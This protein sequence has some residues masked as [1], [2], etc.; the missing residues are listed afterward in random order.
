MGTQQAIHLT[1][2]RPHRDRDHFH[3]PAV[4]LTGDQ[5]RALLEGVPGATISDDGD[6]I[7]VP[8]APTFAAPTLATT[9]LADER[10]DTLLDADDTTWLQHALATYA[11]RINRSE[12]LTPHDQARANDLRAALPTSRARDNLRDDQVAAIL[13]ATD[14]ADG[15]V[16]EADD[17]GAGK[18]AISLLTVWSRDATPGIIVCKPGLRGMWERE[19][20]KWLG[21]TYT[22]LTLDG[23]KPL[24]GGIPTDVDFV[25]VG[26]QV[27]HH[28]IDELVEF[29]AR[30][31]LVDESQQIKTLPVT[32]RAANAWLN[33]P[34]GKK[35]R[36]PR[37]GSWRTWAVQTLAKQPHVTTV[38]L[39]SATPNPNG[40]HLELLPQLDAL[41]YLDEFGGP[42]GFKRR[43]CRYCKPCDEWNLDVCS[44][45]TYPKRFGRENTDGSIN[46]REL[47]QRLRSLTMMRRSARQLQRDVDAIR[48]VDTPVDLTKDGRREYDRAEHDFI[49]YVKEHAAA[50]AADRGLTVAQAVARA[51]RSAQ[52]DHETLVQATHLRRLAAQG[53]I[54]DTVKY[55]EELVGSTAIDGTSEKAVVFAYHREVQDALLARWPNAPR[56]LAASEQPKDSIAADTDRF[57][58]DPDERLIVC[59]LDAAS[60]G[61]TLTAAWH[62]V[63]TQP[64]FV[65]AKVRQAVGRVYARSND[66]HSATLHRLYAPRT[67]EE[68]V[69]DTLDAKRTVASVTL[70]GQSREWGEVEKSDATITE[71]IAERLLLRQQRA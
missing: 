21:D 23:Q 3:V 59:S 60:E 41:G 63:L 56:I 67:F 49:E 6:T 5:R 35:P 42:E 11:Q 30:S 48:V 58:N 46:G 69:I 39:L 27:L 19:V 45:R 36:K 37:S 22:T 40:R 29:G 68:D 7:S 8:T 66:P 4:V 20:P 17:N 24:D 25:I 50:T 62:V 1:D 51:V 12:A 13:Y 16:L 26:F 61:H 44:H 65:P 64:D 53:R 52:G 55:V 28:R 2:A 9:L 34:D 15:R 33:P 31:V 18:G 57:Q 71:E 14:V 32:D 38:A 47:R 54:D 43:Y 70:D 10:F